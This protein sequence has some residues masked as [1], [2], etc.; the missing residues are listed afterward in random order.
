MS[1]AGPRKA[2]EQQAV[3]EIGGAWPCSAAWRK[4][5]AAFWS[6]HG[7][8]LSGPPCGPFSPSF[9]FRSSCAALTLPRAAGLAPRQAGR[10]RPSRCPA[11]VRCLRPRRTSISPTPA[12]PRRPAASAGPLGPVASA[13]TAAGPRR[14]TGSGST[15]LHFRSQQRH[16]RR[17]HQASPATGC[18][19]KRARDLRRGNRSLYTGPG[20]RLLGKAYADLS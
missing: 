3:P 11:R 18:A 2:C 20:T 15:A 6:G 5:C 9:L 12:G 1:L 13:S 14:P 19:I 7:G 8:F 17:H 10:N 4:T 16:S